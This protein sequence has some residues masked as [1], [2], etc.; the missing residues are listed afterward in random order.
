M[1]ELVAVAITIAVCA[2]MAV[3]LHRDAI[4]VKR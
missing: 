4:P 3:T 2:A 1:R